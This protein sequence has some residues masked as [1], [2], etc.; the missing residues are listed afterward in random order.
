MLFLTQPVGAFLFT[1]CFST[2]A[3]CF[4][5]YSP[6]FCLLAE[7]YP[8]IID[9]ELTTTLTM[10]RPVGQVDRLLVIWGPQGECVAFYIVFGLYSK[11]SSLSCF[12]S[13]WSLLEGPTGLYSYFCLAFFIR[14]SIFHFI[15][16]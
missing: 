8:L 13:V 4:L 12:S 6:P 2:P 14:L 15:I 10:G 7:V 11:V 9:L 1:L 5:I 16:Q 3:Y